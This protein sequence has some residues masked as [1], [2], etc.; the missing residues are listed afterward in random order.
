[1]EHVIIYLHDSSTKSHGDKTLFGHGNRLNVVTKTGQVA[2][3][4]KIAATTVITEAGD[5]SIA[6]TAI[7]AT[8]EIETTEG[9]GDEIIV[10]RDSPP[11]HSERYKLI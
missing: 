5:N 11:V 6:V 2:T 3:P 1:M 9:T 8:T 7:E 4:I 10:N